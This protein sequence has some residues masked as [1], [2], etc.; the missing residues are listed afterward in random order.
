[1]KSEYT[2]ALLLVLAGGCYQGDS[3]NSTVQINDSTRLVSTQRE[4][5]KII[6]DYYL[7][8]EKDVKMDLGVS[9]AEIIERVQSLIDNGYVKK[10]AIFVITDD[11]PKWQTVDYSTY[12][13][14]MARHAV[15]SRRYHG[16]QP[17]LPDSS[18]MQSIRSNILEAL[19]AD[20]VNRD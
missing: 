17:K 13:E 15:A 20:S 6:W 1:M 3:Q 7:S 2:L 4:L 8:I 18:S 11:G 16:I 12:K 14:F 19:K 5:E 9:E 10:P